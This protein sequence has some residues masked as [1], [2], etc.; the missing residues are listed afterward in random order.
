MPP[1]VALPP[2]PAGDDQGVT[3]TE[4]P[5]QADQPAADL[6]SPARLH[7]EACITCGSTEPPLVPAGHRHTPTQAGKAPLGWAVVAC[8]N[9][10]SEGS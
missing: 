10:A 1:V 6:V 7:G 4:V 5:E 8:P 2:I 9:H 3:A